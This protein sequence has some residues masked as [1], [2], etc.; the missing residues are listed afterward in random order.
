MYTLIYTGIG[1]YFRE[2]HLLAEKAGKK[3]GEGGG[4]GPGVEDDG[5]EGG[6]R[7]E[8][9]SPDDWERQE[10][11]ERK[12]KLLDSKRAFLLRQACLIL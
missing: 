4:K 3:S 11:I 7:E 5:G 8:V 10:P 9:L 12:L 2:W 6:A 1:Y